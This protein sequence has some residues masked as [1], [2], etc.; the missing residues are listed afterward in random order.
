MTYLRMLEEKGI[1]INYAELFE[2]KRGASRKLEQ[3]LGKTN[4]DMCKTFV[5]RK[6]F[7]V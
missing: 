6:R 4:F 3:L 2:V 7:N 1:E 5:K